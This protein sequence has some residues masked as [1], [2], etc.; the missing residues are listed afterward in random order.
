MDNKKIAGGCSTCL[1]IM[2]IQ[3]SIDIDLINVIWA[4]AFIITSIAVFKETLIGYWLALALSLA[5]GIIPVIQVWGIISVV[6]DVMLPEL[7][8]CSICVLTAAFLI[9]KKAEPVN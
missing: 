6:I 2:A 8:V 4:S 1:V 7:I 3:A 9:V 5:A